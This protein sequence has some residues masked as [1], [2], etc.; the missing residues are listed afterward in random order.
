LVF[1][2]FLDTGDVSQQSA[3]KDIFPQVEVTMKK[4]ELGTIKLICTLLVQSV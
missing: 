4:N 1:H 2:F 3:E